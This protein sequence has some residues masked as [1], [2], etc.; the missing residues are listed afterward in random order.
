MKTLVVCFSRG[1]RTLKVAK[2]IETLTE[3]DLFEVKTDKKYGGYFKALG[4]ANKEYKSGELPT[5]I[6]DVKD[7]ESYDRV[8]VGFPIW[9]GKCPMVMQS[10]LKSHDWTGKEVHPFATSGMSGIEGAVPQVTECCVGANIH[11]GLRTG[12]P[13][14]AELKAWIEK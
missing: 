6:G 5:V 12:K 13:K 1:G 3:G 2:A 14:E 10:F 8:F 11:E 4:V 9:Y 7:W